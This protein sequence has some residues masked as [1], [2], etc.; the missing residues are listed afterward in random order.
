MPDA[1]RVLSR[2]EWTR[3]QEEHEQ[4]ALLFV[5]PH[6]ARRSA[7]Q[8]HP[9]WDF[10]FDYYR[11]RASHLTRWHPG[12]G[13]A[14][15]DATVTPASPVT[16]WRDYRVAQD[17][18]AALDLERFLAR[19]GGALAQIRA[20]LASISTAPPHFSCF[21]LHEWAMV[22]RTERP[23]HDLPLRLGARGTD[24][25]VES[26]GIRCTHFDA[27][28][29]FTPAASPLNLTVLT[30]ERQSLDDQP[31]CVH[32]TMDLYKWAA[33]MGPLVPGE[34]LLDCFEL[35]V[36][37]RRLDM[38]ASPYDCRELGFDVV[39][40]ETPDGKAEY[41]RRQ[42]ELAD[43]ARPLRNRLVALLSAL[44]TDRIIPGHEA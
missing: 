41:V 8:L 6:L 26:H 30:R 32:A 13:T 29:F 44:P 10:L 22:Y 21:G 39:P 2:K 9:V 1:T 36:D 35:A 40:I 43:R 17:G 16:E 33:K 19:R 38:E 25:V 15:A 14:L 24:A 12:V 7:G 27:Y 42:R 28:R 18:T 37:A 5:G 31:G 34:L 23:R 20:L 11:L 4:R 3:A